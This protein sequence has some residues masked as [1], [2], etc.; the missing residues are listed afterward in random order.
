MKIKLLTL[1]LI[2]AMVQPALASEEHNHPADGIH[3]GVAHIDI[4]GVEAYVDN[5][6]RQQLK[7][8]KLS[9]GLLKSTNAVTAS[10]ENVI[11]VGVVIHQE[12][13]N[14]MKEQLI[15]DKD[16]KHYEN[17]AQFAIARIKAKF[18]F[19]NDALEKQG[20]SG[21]F[22]PVYYTTIS[23][24]ITKHLNASESGDFQNVRDCVY[25]PDNYLNYS[26]KKDYCTAQ[27][28]DK[29]RAALSTKVDLMFYVRPFYEGEVAVGHGGYLSAAAD[30]DV[31]N[32]VAKQIVNSGQSYPDAVYESLRF[33]HYNAQ[34]MMHEF[35]HVLAAGHEIT[36]T[37]PV[38]GDGSYGRAYSC[39][40]AVDTATGEKDYTSKRFTIMVSGAALL[41]KPH[42]AFYSDPDIFVEGDA[43]G[44]AGVADNAK[45]VSENLPLAANVNTLP[46]K[47]SD[48]FFVQSDLIF[49]RTEQKGVI[50]IRR[51][52]DLTKPAYVNVLAEDG[53]A[54]E[55]RDFDFG[56]KEVVFAAGESEKTVE[57]T[58]LERNE[59]H[60]DTKFN[61]KMI[62]AMYA[63]Y[64]SE[65][66]NVTITS[67]NPLQ[68]GQVGFKDSQITTAEGNLVE[69]LLT[70]TNGTD[71]DATFNVVTANGTGTAGVD[72][73]AAN[74]TVTIKSGQ[75]SASVMIETTSRAGN[76]GARTVLLSISDL[77]GATA[78]SAQA[79]ITIND[80]LQSGTVGFATTAVTATESGSATLNI[81]R[82]NGAE[83]AVSVN[84]KTVSGS[85][86]AGT[87]FNTVDQAVNFAEG[88]TTASV[89][90]TLINRSGSQGSRSLSVE[91]SNPV[92]GA[93]IG[94][95]VA[96]VTITDAPSQPNQ[97]GDS[98][99]GSSGGSTSIWFLLSMLITALVRKVK[100]QG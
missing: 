87:D 93:A 10:S 33:G 99:E 68:G 95:S 89:T 91:L 76:Q 47:D 44:A 39:G 58:M 64:A 46:A 15:K 83:G 52:G 29:A 56:L 75:N 88:Q 74:Q 37:Q 28:F 96:T 49:N 30:Y 80:A 81:T 4:G 60:A 35:G 12:Y 19:Y 50:T 17:G 32:I 8:R 54:W 71:G 43:C 69:V 77:T 6:H 97:G 7:S 5:F 25:W 65:P 57:F 92:G 45:Y 63:T 94:S 9:L 53:T 72:Y 41:T 24:E 31:Y 84:V 79:T 98:S 90:V 100:L 51:T 73:K 62:G 1:T 85:A 70:R 86:I 27:G 3:V 59:G 61:V 16:G 38:F 36:D 11:D 42:H 82:T 34:V 2:A 66:L 18:D 13:I 20:F 26:Q 78:G 23:H 22:N 21:R 55:Q 48:V 14:Q 67:D 40:P